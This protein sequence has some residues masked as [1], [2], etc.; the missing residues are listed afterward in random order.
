MSCWSHQI[1]RL[2]FLK[3]GEADWLQ[4]ALLRTMNFYTDG[5]RE[6]FAWVIVYGPEQVIVPPGFVAYHSID[7]DVWCVGRA[8]PLADYSTNTTMVCGRL[9]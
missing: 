6:S 5:P 1:Y 2:I 8:W 4:R 3:C 7:S 9:L